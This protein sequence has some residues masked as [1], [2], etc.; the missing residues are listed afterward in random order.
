MH[1]GLAQPSVGSSV[2]SCTLMK[3]RFLKT[4]NGGRISPASSCYG[5]CEVELRSV[6]IPWGHGGAQSPAHTWSC[7][8]SASAVREMHSTEFSMNSSY[9]SRTSAWRFMASRRR[10]HTPP[11]EH[12]ASVAWR[13]WARVDHPSWP[14]STAHC[15]PSEKLIECVTAYSW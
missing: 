13:E 1:G 15:Q 10:Y 3:R 8:A 2:S 14:E 6:Y 11:K 5:Q 7:A 12:G 4:S 9:P